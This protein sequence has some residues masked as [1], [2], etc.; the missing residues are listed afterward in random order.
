MILTK[1]ANGLILKRWFADHIFQRILKNTSWL[2]VGRVI[3]GATGLGYLSLATHSL[4][5]ELFGTLVMVQTYIRVITGLTTFQSWQAVIRYGAICL[6]KQ[7]KA[8]FQQLIKLTTLLD[9]L[10]VV[11]GGAIAVLAASYV[12][13][14]VG[15]SEAI[16]HQVQFCSPLILFTI[17]ATPTGLLRLYNRFDLLAL[18]SA[19]SPLIHLL[20]TV[21]AA[22]FQAPLWGYLLAWWMAEAAGGVFLLLAGWREGWK[23]GLLQSMDWSLSDLRQSH[24]GILKFC[25][26]SNLDSSL[27]LAMRQTSPL[28]VGAIANPAAVA[29]FRISYELATPFKGLAQL[30]NQSLYPE[31]A[32]LSSQGKWKKFT[33][34]ILR[35]GGMAVGTGATI[36]VLGI[37]LGK[38]ILGSVFGEAFIPAYSTLVLLVAA[39]VLTM[40]S[41]A[42][43]P[44]L[45]AMGRPSLPLQVNAIAILVVY[46]PLLVVLTQHFGA[47]GAGMATLLAS[48]LILTLNSVLIWN[49]LSQQFSKL[50]RY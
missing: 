42:L 14:D 46:F 29:L 15:W 1:Y 37:I 19:L 24:P 21:I 45:Y 12:G 48:A 28:I 18:Q 22:I 6:Q 17:V 41:G 40:A 34:L 3:T 9:V 20:G 8:A 11:A 33:T 32:H 35:S 26:V 4:G 10:G 36:C 27:P 2:L 47:M 44:A 7:D 5:I 43:A 49:Q 30:L 31:L 13:P 39:G 23:R 25:M 50:L 38:W 16:I